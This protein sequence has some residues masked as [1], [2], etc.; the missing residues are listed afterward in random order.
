MMILCGFAGGLV[1]AVRRSSIYGFRKDEVLAGYFLAGIGSFFGGKIFFVVQGFQRFLVLHETKGESFF[2][3]FSNAG[4]VFYGG[5]I[6][7]LLCMVLAARLFHDPPFPLMD[8]LLPSLPLAQ[9]FGRIGCFF[10]GCCYGVPSDFGVALHPDGFGPADEKRLPIQLIEAAGVF[11]LFLVLLQTGKK[12][13]AK[14]KLL[15]IY[16]FGYGCLRFILEFFRG[17]A[18][19]GFAGAFSVSQ[20][21][22]LV[23]IILGLFFWRFSLTA[24]IATNAENF[25]SARSAPIGRP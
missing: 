14:G 18:V 3:F 25:T 15:S 7:C 5:M 10:A 21:I 2:Q 17:D 4:L 13:T 12:P 19:R 20:W 24:P 8:T 9:A 6:G 22:S 11:I 16:L 23:C 1:V